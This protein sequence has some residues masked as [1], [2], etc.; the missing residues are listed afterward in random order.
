MQDVIF[1]KLA[2]G[3]ETVYFSYE[4]R[5][6]FFPEISDKLENKMLDAISKP[7][8]ELLSVC[9]TCPTRCISEKDAYCTMFDEEY[10][11]GDI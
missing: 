1:Q 9:E 3:I 2:G 8:D 5:E 11:Y 4:M 6:S 10:L 7:W